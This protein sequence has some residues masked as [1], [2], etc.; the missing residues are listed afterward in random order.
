[1]IYAFLGR[2]RSGKNTCAEIL[3][4]RLDEVGVSYHELAFADT[5]KKT[6][7]SM[8]N[9]PEELFH[10][11]SKKETP[12]ILGKYSPREL[13]CWYGDMTKNKFGQDFFVKITREII[14]NKLKTVDVVIVTDLRF[15]IEAYAMVDAGAHIIYT[16]RDKVLGPLPAEAHDSESAVYVSVGILKSIGEEAKFTEIHNNGTLEELVHTMSV[17]KLNIN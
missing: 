3:K 4:A 10:D 13:L 17:Y 14:T 2:K 7:A 15:P 5:M 8:F 16:N 1:M 6:L 11:Q 9:V 12:C